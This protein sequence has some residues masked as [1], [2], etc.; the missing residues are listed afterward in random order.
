MSHTVV[1]E[2]GGLLL[3]SWVTSSAAPRFVSNYRSVIC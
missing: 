1:A 3:M 2:P